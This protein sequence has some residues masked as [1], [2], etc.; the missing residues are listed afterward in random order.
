MVVTICT[1]ECKPIRSICDV[2]RIFYIFG[3]ADLVAD[4]R[5]LLSVVFFFYSSIIE[6]KSLGKTIIS[7]CAFGRFL[8]VSH[9]V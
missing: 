3:T 6:S 7:S 5:L 2:E 4:R 9:G 8:N 1:D